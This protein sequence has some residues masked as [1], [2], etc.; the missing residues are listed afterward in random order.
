MAGGGI[1]GV[2]CCAARRARRSASVTGTGWRGSSSGRGVIESVVP[3][4]THAHAPPSIGTGVAAPQC[5][6]R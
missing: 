2:S 4:R 5:E 3:Q 1:I 6:Q